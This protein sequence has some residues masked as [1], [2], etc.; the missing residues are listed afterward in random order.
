MGSVGDIIA[1]AKMGEQKAI[2]VEKP[3]TPRFRWR[4]CDV[5]AVHTDAPGAW[6]AESCDGLQGHCLAGAGRTEH[7]EV[8]AARHRQGKRAKAETARADFQIVEVEAHRK[9][10]SEH[11]GRAGFARP[12]RLHAPPPRPMPRSGPTLGVADA[13]LP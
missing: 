13:R 5:A 4:G 2:L 1:H 3:D 8:L 6:R 9:G 7:D 10:E 12:G 11:A